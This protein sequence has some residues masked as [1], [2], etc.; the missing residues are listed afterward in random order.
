MDKIK[1]IQ[2]TRL[3]PAAR[4]HGGLYMLYQV[5]L[6]GIDIVVRLD[7][8][9]VQAFAHVENAVVAAVVEHH[10]LAAPLVIHPAPFHEAREHRVFD[11]VAHKAVTVVSQV[12]RLELVVFGSGLEQRELDAAILVFALHLDGHGLLGPVTA[13]LADN[14]KARINLPVLLRRSTAVFE[15]L[16]VDR[17]FQ[18]PPVIRLAARFRT[19]RNPLA[20]VAVLGIKHQI[21]VHADGHD[22]HRDA[23]VDKERMARL[24]RDGISDKFRT[25]YCRIAVHHI[26]FHKFRRGG[27]RHG[28][29]EGTADFAAIFRCRHGNRQFFIKTRGRQEADLGS[30]LIVVISVVGTL[31]C[32]TC[33]RVARGSRTARCSQTA[34]NLRGTPR[35]RRRRPL[36]TAGCAA[37]EN[38]VEIVFTGISTTG[39]LFQVPGIERIRTFD[40]IEI[41]HG[42]TGNT[43]IAP[44]IRFIVTARR[45]KRQYNRAEQNMFK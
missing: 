8:M 11:V 3:R 32:R 40:A 23:L 4:G 29:I 34:R 37:R 33:S 20:V 21:R 2:V 25:A 1:H 19:V 44:V 45:H 12:E 9:F 43:P 10:H 14:G 28:T 36:G 39:H 35:R 27:S 5:H 16:H 26:G 7:E 38:D 42:R 6:L 18:V 22:R 41:Q 30:I 31:R 15:E 13:P 24:A 17:E